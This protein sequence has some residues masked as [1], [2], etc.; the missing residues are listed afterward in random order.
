MCH[1]QEVAYSTII[2]SLSFMGQ[3]T[4][5]SQFEKAVTS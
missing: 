4:L 5:A 1:A 2:G 3:L